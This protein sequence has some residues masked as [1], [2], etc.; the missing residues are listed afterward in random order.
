[1]SSWEVYRKGKLSRRPPDFSLQILITR[2]GVRQGESDPE[3]R[4]GR[5]EE[6]DCVSILIALAFFSFLLR[7]LTDWATQVS[8]HFPF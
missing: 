6:D 1:M 4:V 2:Q 7:C 3:R 5:R 8:C